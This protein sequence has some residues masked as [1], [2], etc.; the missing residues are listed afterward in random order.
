MFKSIDDAVAAYVAKRDEMQADDKI[1]KARKA[2]Q[3]GEL[4]KISMWLRDKAD[5]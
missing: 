4:D 2:E 3:V 5:E 1:A